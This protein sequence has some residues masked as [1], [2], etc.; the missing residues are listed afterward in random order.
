MMKLFYT[1]TSPYARKVRIAILE[2]GLQDRVEAIVA[3]PFESTLPIPNPLGKVPTLIL[4]DGTLLFDSPVICAFLLGPDHGGEH[5]P[6]VIEQQRQQALGDGII[7]AA[8]AIVMEQRRPEAQRSPD[9]LE[10]WDQAIRKSLA[11]AETQPGWWSDDFGI[12]AISFA[13]ALG[14][15]DFRLPEIDWRSSTTAL[16]RWFDMVSGRASMVK[17]APPPA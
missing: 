15:L 16:P 13:C 6:H 11:F 2:R 17:T 1:P 3:N 9:W 12:G 4:D 14:Y 10:R 5:T 8:F 7:D